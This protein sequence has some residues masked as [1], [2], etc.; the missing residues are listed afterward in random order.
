MILESLP[1][2]GAPDFAPLP[3]LSDRGVVEELR[4]ALRQVA[5]W[6]ARAAELLAEVERRGIPRGEGF[7]SATGWLMALIGDPPA[8]CRGRVETARRLR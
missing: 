4:E 8:V 3:G 7:G 2:E 1:D 6:E 5:V